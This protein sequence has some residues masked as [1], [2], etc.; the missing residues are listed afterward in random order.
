MSY[1][2]QNNIHQQYPQPNYYP[3]QQSYYQQKTPFSYKNPDIQFQ[4]SNLNDQTNRFDNSVN[5]RH[6]QNQN[7][8]N[9]TY[10]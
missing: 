1:Y 6:T 9:Y 10:D 7:V 8:L 4:R 3:Q 5:P 2:T